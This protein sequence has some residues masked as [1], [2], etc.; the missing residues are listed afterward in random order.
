M[1]LYNPNLSFLEV[2]LAKQRK[3]EKT[4][5]ELRVEKINPMLLDQ[6]L[7]WNWH[8]TTKHQKKLAPMTMK[9]EMGL[10]RFYDC[11]QDR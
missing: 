3:R 10:N 7:H 1:V 11:E 2:Y 8:S 9:E 5:A 6:F 4:Y